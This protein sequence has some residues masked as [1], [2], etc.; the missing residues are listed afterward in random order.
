VN[1]LTPPDDAGLGLSQVR[2]VGERDMLLGC[3]RRAVAKIAPTLRIPSGADE[4]TGLVLDE[5][6]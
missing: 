1:T 6:E 2:R 5:R 4:L 3:C